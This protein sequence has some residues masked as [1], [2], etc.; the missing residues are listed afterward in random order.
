MP[1][2]VVDVAVRVPV[3]DPVGMGVRV[4]VWIVGRAGFGP[5][6]HGARFGENMGKAR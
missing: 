6:R 4:R 3:H 2:V 5:F 1:V